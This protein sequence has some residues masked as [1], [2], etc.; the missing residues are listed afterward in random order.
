MLA[1]LIQGVWIAGLGTYCGYCFLKQLKYM[2]TIP[3]IAS[4]IQNTVDSLS[5]QCMYVFI[6]LGGCLT[7]KNLK[8]L[9]I[10]N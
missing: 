10:F 4:G 9:T 6:S 3:S 2:N 8:I 5:F 7:S 1:I